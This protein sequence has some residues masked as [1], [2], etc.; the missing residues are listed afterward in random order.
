MV[1]T[2]TESGSYDIKAHRK[3]HKFSEGMRKKE[4][5]DG[6]PWPI[7]RSTS[8]MYSGRLAIR[9]IDIPLI[10]RLRNQINTDRNNRIS[11]V[12]DDFKNKRKLSIRDRIKRLAEKA[13]EAMTDN[14]IREF[15]DEH[16]REK[17]K[18]PMIL[19]LMG[20][21]S[22]MRELD[23]P[24]VALSLHDHRTNEEQSSDKNGGRALVEGN[25]NK[26]ATWKEIEESDVFQSGNG[27]DLVLFNPVGAIHVLPKSRSY[28]Y[29][30]LQ[31]VYPLMSDESLLAA[32]VPKQIT[33]D[34]EEFREMLE[35]VPG[36]HCDFVPAGKVSSGNLF[37]QRTPDAPATIQELN[38]ALEG[39]PLALSI[40]TN[41][42]D[43]PEAA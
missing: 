12:D 13:K 4:E 42:V 15:S 6:K 23:T 5:K 37:L 33:Q 17:G 29:S 19:D 20:I 2:Q 16:L 24:G 26:R 7:Q 25:I 30:L 40:E 38:A 21:G 36:L 28:Y 1:D 31:R 3:A 32:Q 11:A 35:T 10:N 9:G 14:W 8:S 43:L 34:M 39:S 22:V 27:F 18:K 41:P